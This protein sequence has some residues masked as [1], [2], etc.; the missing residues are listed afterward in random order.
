MLISFPLNPNRW[1]TLFPRLP[2]HSNGPILDDDLLKDSKIASAIEKREKVKHE[3]DIV[4]TDRSVGGRVSG[5][6]A[7]KWG[8][9]DFAAGG[10]EL[11]MVFSG[12][13]GQSFGAFTLPGMKMEVVG[14]VQ[15]PR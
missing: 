7:K 10:G 8:N 3:V 11:H 15:L 12:S 6:I 14:E 1:P 9:Q 13:A 4:N 5:V 2:T